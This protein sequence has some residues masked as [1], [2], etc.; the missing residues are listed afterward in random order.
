ME[1]KFK[2]LNALNNLNPQILKELILKEITD[3]VTSAVKSS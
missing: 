1:A 3:S 2:Q